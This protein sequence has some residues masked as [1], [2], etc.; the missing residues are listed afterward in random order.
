M[1]WLVSD[2]RGPDASVPRIVRDALHTGRKARNWDTSLTSCQIAIV[3]TYNPAASPEPVPIIPH[4]PNDPSLKPTSTPT[5]ASDADV[6]GH[7]HGEV[8]GGGPTE[9]VPPAP[10]PPP[11]PPPVF[12]A[13][14]LA[15]DA[16]G[17]R[18]PPLFRELIS[19]SCVLSV[20]ERNS[21]YVTQSTCW[22]GLA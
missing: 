11:P 14:G 19:V 16:G 1:G 21:R 17:Y 6:G 12:L 20:R 2:Y 10:L 18:T 4:G 8:D 7:E 22:F 15:R 13:L 9:V 5:M 3:C